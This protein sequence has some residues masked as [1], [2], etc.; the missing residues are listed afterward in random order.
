MTGEF[1][2]AVRIFS[3]DLKIKWPGNFYLTTQ[4]K[5]C[6]VFGRGDQKDGG[7]IKDSTGRS[8]RREHSG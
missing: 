6:R 1:W 8:L 4:A 3:A 7:G 5:V 2:C